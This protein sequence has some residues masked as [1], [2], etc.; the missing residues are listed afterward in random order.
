MK[1]RQAAY[2]LVPVPDRADPEIVGRSATARTALIGPR[3]RANAE[4]NG[5]AAKPAWAGRG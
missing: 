5:P 3:C 1:W 4:P 2:S